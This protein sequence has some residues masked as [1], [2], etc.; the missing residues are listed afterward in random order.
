[1]EK[2]SYFLKN[3]LILSILSNSYLIFTAGV[4]PK[5]IAGG[6]IEP[7]SD[8]P[9]ASVLSIVLSSQLRT[10]KVDYFDFFSKFC[11]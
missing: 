7:P 2:S 4:I 8:A 9:E 3:H 6:G 10:T 5:K 11:A 1:M